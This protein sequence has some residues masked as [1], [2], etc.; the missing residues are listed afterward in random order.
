M[1]IRYRWQTVHTQ[2]APTQ[3][4]RI[5]DCKSQVRPKEQ[6]EHQVRSLY[7]IQYGR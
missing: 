2:G 6:D 3:D 1:T 5:V 7:G 4:L